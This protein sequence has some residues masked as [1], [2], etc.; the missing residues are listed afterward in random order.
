MKK[1]LSFLILIFLINWNLKAEVKFTDPILRHIY[2]KR[3][4]GYYYY[5]PKD[6]WSTTKTF[7]DLNV[8]CPVCHQRI[9]PV[10]I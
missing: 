10:R 5:C 3:M 2:E 4:D 8:R 9:L 6:N 1:I 7:G